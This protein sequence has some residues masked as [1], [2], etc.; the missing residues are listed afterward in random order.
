VTAP[1][2]QVL[3]SASLPA[4]GEAVRKLDARLADGRVFVIEGAKHAAHHTHAERFVA[5]VSAFLLE[6]GTDRDRA[7][8][9]P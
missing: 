4:F 6:S 8:L 3:G 1:V 7:T 9:G 5:E 2:L